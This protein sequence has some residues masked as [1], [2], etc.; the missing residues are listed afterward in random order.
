MSA[1]LE[2][3]EI[4]NEF[5]AVRL[6]IRPHGRGTRLEVTSGQ[7]ATSALLDATVL[8]ALT[9]FDPESLA[10]LVGVAMQAPDEPI[11][12]ASNAVLDGETEQA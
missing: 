4:R 1:A 6:T 10:E 3:A 7:L 2:S 12:V 5:A 9:R 11:E 8:E